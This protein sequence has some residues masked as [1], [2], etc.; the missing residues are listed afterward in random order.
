MENYQGAKYL[1][2]L[3]QMGDSS[4]AYF[5]TA[6]Y[7]R[8]RKYRVKRICKA[9]VI[10]VAVAAIGLLV[11]DMMRMDAEICAYVCR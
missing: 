10:G 7:L 11:C 6:R 4:A 2:R 8:E 1:S 3:S 5:I 9:L